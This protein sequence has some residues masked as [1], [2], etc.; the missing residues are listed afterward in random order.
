M[1]FTFGVN[2][3]GF[4]RWR[5]CCS[6]RLHNI[7]LQ[8]NTSLFQRICFQLK[9]ICS[10][11]YIV[12][13]SFKSFPIFQLFLNSENCPRATLD[14]YLLL[15]LFKTVSM[16]ESVGSCRK[17]FISKAIKAN[18]EITLLRACIIR[19]EAPLIALRGAAL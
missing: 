14:V 16:S 12:I 17:V 5:E 19:Q 2:R 13:Y 8:N 15:T 10:R 4:V 3:H 7:F 1:S 9:S 11:L 6:K 18:V